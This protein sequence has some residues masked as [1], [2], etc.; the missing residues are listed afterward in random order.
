MRGKTMQ[1]ASDEFSASGDNQIRSPHPFAKADFD[2][3]TNIER[4]TNPEEEQ[5]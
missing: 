1:A 3:S 2:D 4:G 5:Q